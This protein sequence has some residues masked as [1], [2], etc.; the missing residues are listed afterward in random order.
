MAGCTQKGRPRRIRFMRILRY[1]LLGGGL[2][3]VVAVIGWFIVN[4][5]VFTKSAPYKLVRTL[6][7][8]EIRDY[9]ALT[10]AT[11]P[12]SDSEGSGGFRQL[13]GFITGGNAR[14]EKIPMTTPVLVER[15]AGN[16]RMS[17]VLPE[18]VEKNGVPEPTGKEV[19]LRKLEAG[20]Y[21]VLRFK[22]R[23][24]EANQ[25]AAA[26]K[27]Q[28]WLAERH[29]PAQSE[30]VFAYYDP[31]WTPTILRRNEVMLRVPEGTDLA[32]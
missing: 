10:L 31:P 23:G 9:P 8:F 2:L 28:A 13:F 32:Q 4:S 24:E 1:L 16:W 3:V 14:A 11:A 21:V 29:I 12:M 5:R 27:L 22:N 30:P 7:A 19:R 20:R 26:E 15:D 18:A 25:K 17:F 6:G